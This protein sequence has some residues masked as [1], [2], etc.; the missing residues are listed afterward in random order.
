[1]TGTTVH[2]QRNL[3][4]TVPVVEKHNPS[5]TSLF[6]RIPK[7]IH[8]P[9]LNPIP[10]SNPRIPNPPLIIQ[11][12]IYNIPRRLPNLLLRRLV[13]AEC[14]QYINRHFTARAIRTCY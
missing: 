6:T 2:H 8:Y 1:M 10:L 9:H 4:E 3:D 11:T 14:T 5:A 7:V 13:R 12:G